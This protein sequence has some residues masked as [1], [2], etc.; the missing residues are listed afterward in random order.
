MNEPQTLPGLAKVAPTPPPVSE[1]HEIQVATPPTGLPGYEWQGIPIDIIRHFNIDLRTTPAKDLEQI[2]EITEWAKSKTLDEPS[3][4]NILSQIAKVQ[5]QLGVPGVNE[6]AYE[7]TWRFIKAQKVI[8]EMH[9]RQE[10]MR[11]SAWL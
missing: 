9:K 2:K 8:D 10:S 7:K 3:I 4:G 5:R 6:R 1:T 11:T